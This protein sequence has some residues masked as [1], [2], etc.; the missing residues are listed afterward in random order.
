MG[1]DLLSELMY[2]ILHDARERLLKPNAIMGTGAPPFAWLLLVSGWVALL[3]QKG[4]PKV[5]AF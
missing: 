2:N 5:A 3:K 4:D 1:A